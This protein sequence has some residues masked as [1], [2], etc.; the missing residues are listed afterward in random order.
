MSVWTSYLF[1]ALTVLLTVFGQIVIKWEVVKHGPAP[2][3]LVGKLGFV[4]TLMI[5]PWIAGGLLAAL[6]ASATWMLAMTRLP[7]SHAYPFVSLS[8]VLVLFLSGL[9]LGEPITTAKVVG[10]ALIVAGVA[11]SSQG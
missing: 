6:A 10:V 7:L 9:L 1:V 11:V 8:F 3:N 5:N 4:A 2:D